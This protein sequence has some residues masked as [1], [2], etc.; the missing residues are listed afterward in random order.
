MSWLGVIINAMDM[1][2]NKLYKMVRD[3]KTLCAAS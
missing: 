2:L 1:N 3:R